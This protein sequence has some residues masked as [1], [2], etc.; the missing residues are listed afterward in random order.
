MMST[1]RKIAFPE[2]EKR[3][4]KEIVK[5]LKKLQPEDRKI[6]FYMMKGAELFTG[7]LNKADDNT[8]VAL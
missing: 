7:K 4:T 1:E 6:L 3:A 5:E 2:E 8:K